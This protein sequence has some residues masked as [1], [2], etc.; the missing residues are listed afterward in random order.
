[1]SGKAITINCVKAETANQGLNPT[2]DNKKADEKDEDEGSEDVT[3]SLLADARADNNVLCEGGSPVKKSK[4]KLTSKIKSVDGY[5]SST[6]YSAPYPQSPPLNHDCKVEAG[7]VTPDAGW[8]PQNRLSPPSV[9]M[10]GGAA[11]AGVHTIPTDAALSYRSV[12][13]TSTFCIR[14][15]QL[16]QPG[17]DSNMNSTDT[18]PIRHGGAREMAPNNAPS[19]SD[20]NSSMTPFTQR[21]HAESQDSTSITYSN[22]RYVSQKDDPPS[23][24]RSSA[25]TQKQNARGIKQ[26]NYPQ[27][28]PNTNLSLVSDPRSLSSVNSEAAAT[29]QSTPNTAPSAS[30]NIPA[31][32][33]TS[34]E[35]VAGIPQA[36]VVTTS[37][38]EN[39]GDCKASQIEKQVSN[40]NWFLIL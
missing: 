17:C 35:V 30:M 26:I 9:V 27:I 34:A 15:K 23:Y 31:S 20:N 24:I 3:T 32:P 8:A 40:Y 11:I 21:E 5:T 13:E 14:G 29:T 2:Q 25:T 6:K 39:E 19:F 10:M 38:D 36:A 7:P 16:I 28:K 12:D 22:N 18:F 1:M 4:L 37:R 33:P